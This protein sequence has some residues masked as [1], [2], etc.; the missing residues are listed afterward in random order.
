MS[1]AQS[2]EMDLDEDTL[3]VL[4][5]RTSNPDIVGYFNDIPAGERAASFEQVL[6]TGVIALRAIETGNQ[7]DFVEKRF[8]SLQ[9]QFD[10]Q[11]DDLLGD[12]GEVPELIEQHFGDDGRLI[13]EV[14]DPGNPDSPIHT[15][16]KNLRR[17]IEQLRTDL[18]VA[19]KE[20][21]LKQQMP[22]KGFEFEEF[23]FDELGGILDVTGDN[24]MKTG[25]ETGYSGDSKKGDFVLEVAD[26][27]KRIAIEAKHSNQSEQQIVDYMGE[28]IE[29]RDADYG[30]FIARE[31]SQ[32]PRKIG[33][34]EEVDDDVLVVALSDG[35]DAPFA[36]ELLKVA[37]R[38]ARVRLR[39]STADGGQDVD[40]ATIQSELTD[41]ERTLSQ[42]SQLKKQCT[43][44]ENS[45]A[46]LWEDVDA[47]QDEV[48]DHF[49][50]VL[51]SLR[52]SGNA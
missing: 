18:Q 34:F 3:R 52:P 47:L 41:A 30:I 10:E 33:W 51:T 48:S 39:S 31:V 20:E 6:R 8:N 13:D 27:G 24:L 49:D 23:L 17:E 38:W 35:E 50:S 9:Q 45:A 1:K 15:L 11:L 21:E 19:D 4:T 36:D 40:I 43:S 32:V 42:F 26:S 2:V 22:Q 5:Y 37:Y 7:V 46:D 28:V 29:N 12:N 14:F 25:T 16:E 44:I